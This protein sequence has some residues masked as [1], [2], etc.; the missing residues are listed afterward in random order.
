MWLSRRM[1]RI[2]RDRAGACGTAP[3]RQGDGA[4]VCPPPGAPSPD[5]FETAMS[6]LFG[7]RWSRDE[8]ARLIQLVEWGVAGRAPAA[9]PLGQIG[10]GPL[11]SIEPGAG[12][13]VELVGLGV[14]LTLCPSSQGAIH[15]ALGA[16]IAAGREGGKS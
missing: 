2:A 13:H 10:G 15:A 1:D 5:P 4:R 11:W 14:R 8:A 12:R 6:A 16:V 3:A 9:S 7:Q